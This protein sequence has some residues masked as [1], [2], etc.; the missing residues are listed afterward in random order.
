MEA[1]DHARVDIRRAAHRGRVAE[2]SRDGLD[3]AFDLTLAGG[4]PASSA[5]LA[6]V[7]TRAYLKQICVD[8]FWHSDPHPGNVLLCADGR[9]C[10]LDF[11]LMR[12]VPAE[13]LDGENL[14]DLLAQAPEVRGQD[15]GGDPPRHTSTS[16]DP[17][18]WLQVR[19]AV[20]VIRTI[21][22]CSPQFGHA[23]RSS[24]RCRQ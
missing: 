3:R 18:Q 12:K 2:I 1:V 20:L 11:G 7:I 16:I 17:P 6:E 9:V 5:E 24:K 15:R 14:A 10:F 21:V 22:E 19:V 8:G 13:Y 4:R 23:E